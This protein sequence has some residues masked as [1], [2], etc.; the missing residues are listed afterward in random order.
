MVAANADD[1]TAS[2]FVPTVAG[3]TRSIGVKGLPPD[4][5]AGEL[6]KGTEIG[7]YVVLDKAGAGGMGVVYSAYDPVLDRRVALKFVRDQA[8]GSS[9]SV[10]AET[11]LL[12]EAQALA[13]LSHPNIA[14]IFDVGT[15]GHNVFWPWSF[16]WARRSGGGWLERNG[17]GRRF[18][19]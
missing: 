15:F 6:P 13:R 7:R 16:W 5:V 11:R 14:T 9:G 4:D 3:D 19:M 2:A 10:G 8:Q 18:S 17:P 1:H 12:R